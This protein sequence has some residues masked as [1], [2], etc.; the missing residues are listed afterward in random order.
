MLKVYSAETANYAKGPRAAPS[1]PPRHILQNIPKQMERLGL[2]APIGIVFWTI[3]IGTCVRL[4]CAAFAIDLT[5]G[6]AYYIANA[7]H[8]AL[9]YFDH[10]PLAFWL[11][12]ATMK[13]TG[14]DALIV[15]RIPFIALFAATTWLM[16]RVGTLLFDEWVGAFSALLLNLSPLFTLSMGA[17]VE[18]DGPLIFFILASALCIIRLASDN[19]PKSETWLWAQAGFWLGLA[20]LSKYYAVLLPVGVTLFALTSREQ[21]NGENSRC[22]VAHITEPAPRKRRHG[23]VIFLVRRGR[24]AVDARR[25]AQHAVLRD[26]RRCGHL[27]EHEP[28]VDAAVGREEGR[29]PAH[30]RIDQKRDAPLG[31]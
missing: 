18:P 3:G 10:P 14:S 11:A 19:K 6:E 2:N 26:Q 9:S 1:E 23:D 24:N 13:L 27:R 28:G 31:E 4:L 16:Y 29:Q 5:F 25:V 17:W 8:F 12:G 30:V 20:L 21:F 15:V 22:I 7:R